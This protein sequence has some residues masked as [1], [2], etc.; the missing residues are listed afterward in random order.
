M[1]VAQRELNKR[2]MPI[3]EEVELRRLVRRVIRGVRR[4]RVEFSIRDL[5][6]KPAGA[7]Y[8]ASYIVRSAK[9]SGQ[10]GAF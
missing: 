9:N 2:A 6:D 1:K 10:K 8:L 3:P 4:Y 5:L 7:S